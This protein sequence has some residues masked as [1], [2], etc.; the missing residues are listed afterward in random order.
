MS[1][2]PVFDSQQWVPETGAAT[3][4]EREND[5]AAAGFTPEDDRVFRSHFQHVNRLADRNYEQ[6]RPVY[7]LGRA[8]V[9]GACPEGRC[10]EEV[11]KDLERGWLS[12]R[13]GGGDWSSVR[14]FAQAG[15]DRARQGRIVDALP[16]GEADRPPYADPVAKDLDP[17]SPESPE[18]T[19]EYQRETTRADGAP[20]LI[21]GDLAVRMPGDVQ[22]STS[23]DEA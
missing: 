7:G 13:V 14:E 18:Q 8:A 11:E 3:G 17:T 5:P 9:Q 1:D 4:D 6:V 19:L 21:V 16:A 20:P 15:F 10:F 2:Q 22:D 12:V 23:S